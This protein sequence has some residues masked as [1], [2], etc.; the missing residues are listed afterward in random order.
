MDLMT[1]LKILSNGAKYD[2][3]CTSSGADRPGNR[4]LG[5]ALAAGCC[6]AFSADGRCISLLKVLMTNQCIYDC[7]YCINRSSNDI[8]RAAFTPEEL[9]ELTIQF[10]RRNYIEGLF[11]SSG[12]IKNP[13]YTME[14]MIAILEILRRKYDFYGYVHAKTIPGAS[15]ELIYK[16]GLLADRLSVN[17]ELPSERSLNQLA[18]HK[19]KQAILTP[20]R[21]IADGLCSSKEERFLYKHAPRFAGAG[22]ATQMIIGATPEN[23]FSILRL[24][25]FLYEKYQLRRVFYSAYIPAV[26]DSLLPAL[27]TK[28]P[29]LREHRLYQADWLIRQYDFSADEILSEETPNFNPYLDPKCNWAINNMGRFPIDVNKASREDLLRIPGIG[30]ISAKRIIIARKAG[31]LGIAELKRIGVVLKRAQYFII[32]RDN[33]SGPHL[34]NET[35]LRA[36]IDPKVYRTDMEQLSLFPEETDPR[37][38]SPQDFTS[39]TQAAEEVVLSLSRSL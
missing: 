11:L 4:G 26:E 9:A 12:I 27:N 8:Q 10:Y 24:A 13:D 1:K 2:A 35:V 28:P 14:K 18:P 30:P 3:A 25:S 16:L 37:L 23:D 20:M 7:K 19:T 33:P 32:T 22:Q 15:P 31:K 34:N 38:P 39:V 21:Q 6:H 17:I 5:S 36:L 29:L